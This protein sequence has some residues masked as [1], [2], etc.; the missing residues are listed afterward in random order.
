MSC[1]VG[2]GSNFLNPAPEDTI[3]I[4]A[5]KPKIEP[6]P[7]PKDRTLKNAEKLQR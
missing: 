3:K 6:T 7:N 5:I 2:S 4:K 1:V